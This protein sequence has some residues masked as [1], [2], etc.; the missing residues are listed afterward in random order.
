M[1]WEQHRARVHTAWRAEWERTHPAPLAATWN[2]LFEGG[3]EIRARL[4]CDL[5]VYLA[6]DLPITADLAFVIECLHTAS[7]LIDDSPLMDNAA[8][9]R[10]QPTLHTRFPLPVVAHLC[11]DVLHMARRIW[12]AHRPATVS[13]GEWNEWLRG[14]LQRLIVGQWCD[15]ER[16]GTALE[17]AS[18][19][20]GVLFEWVAGTV[21]RCVGLDHGFWQQWGNQV[22]VL[23]QWTDD[24]KDREEDRV[25][26][27]RN[28]FLEAPEYRVIWEGVQRG[29]GMGWWT[30]PFGAYVRA[31]FDWCPAA[32]SAPYASLSHIFFS[33]IPQANGTYAND[34]ITLMYHV[35]AVIQEG[36]HA[37]LSWEVSW[38]EWDIEP[39][40]QEAERRLGWTLRPMVERLKRAYQEHASKDVYQRI[41]E[42]WAMKK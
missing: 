14:I 25:A 22:G 13:A 19:K 20:T 39:Y 24:W 41:V 7:L 27:S 8:T 9:R 18:L 21:A 38:E 35:T 12:V 40:L 23:F 5:W 36:D 31:Y 4:F 34:L 30:R 28:A 32:T 29:V 42:E 15:M 2:Y 33:G 16:H 26:G 11:Y 1:A 6:P 10:G 17:L 3:K 37:E